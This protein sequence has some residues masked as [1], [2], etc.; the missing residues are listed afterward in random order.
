MHIIYII[1]YHNLECKFEFLIQGW[2]FKCWNCA[3]N[4]AKPKKIQVWKE[5]SNLRTTHEILDLI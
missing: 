5:A 1:V 4:K 2:L 3:T